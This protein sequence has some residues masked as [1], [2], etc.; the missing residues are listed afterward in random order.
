MII[1]DD[2]IQ[3]EILDNALKI[4]GFDY[5]MNQSLTVI[6]SNPDL[7]DKTKMAI[8]AF[9][10][11]LGAFPHAATILH[12][13]NVS[14]WERIGLAPDSVTPLDTS[15]RLAVIAIILDVCKSILAEESERLSLLSEADTTISPPESE[16][17]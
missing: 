9:A 12:E 16:P 13:I 1:F 5:V 14:G 6:D 7:T 3:A 15:M 8:R 2:T 11:K 17:E 10:I 4:K